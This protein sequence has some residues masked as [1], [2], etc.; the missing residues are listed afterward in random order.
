GRGA[1]LLRRAPPRPPPPCRSGAR[2]GSACAARTR[3]APAPGRPCGRAARPSQF[4][5]RGCL[6]RLRRAYLVEGLYPAGGGN[7]VRISFGSGIPCEKI[8]SRIFGRRPVGL[9]SAMTFP[10]AVAPLCL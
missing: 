6:G 1:W 2:G 5:Y 3:A 4:E 9:K 7:R 8:R 10:S